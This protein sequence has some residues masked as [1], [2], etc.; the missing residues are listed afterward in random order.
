MHHREVFFALRAL[1][2]VTHPFSAKEGSMVGSKINL[3]MISGWKGNL[4]PTK[5]ILASSAACASDHDWQVH[6]PIVTKISLR[7]DVKGRKK[8][9]F[10]PTSHYR[11]EK[12][13][14]ES[15]QI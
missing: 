1:R 2:G 13:V 10:L 9:V 3:M 5:T 4:P 8:K 12:A 15:A 14:Q 11:S 6:L 7:Q